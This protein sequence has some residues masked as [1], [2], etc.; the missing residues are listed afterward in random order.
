[1]TRRRWSAT[2]LLPALLCAASAGCVMPDQVAKL[3]KDVADLKQDL[4]RLERGQEAAAE[5]LAEVAEAVSSRPDE[6]SRAEFADV[7]LR[8]DAINQQHTIVVEQLDQANRRMDRLS[9][10]IQENRERIRQVSS[11]STLLPTPE[12]GIDP[13]SSTGEAAAPDVGAIPSAEA[14]YNAAYADF[15]KGNY[16]LA[17]SGFEEYA[18]R[19]SESDYADNALYWVGEC[20]FSQGNYEVAIRAFDRMLERYPDSDRAAAANLK[21]GLAYLELNEIRQ[22]VVQLRF[23]EDSYPI[24]DEA[25]IA[26]DKLASLGIER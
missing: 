10:G 18:T 11:T 14:L 4:E 2:I 16:A 17:I 1:M 5:R 24:S 15:S 26:R 23:V 12:S 7:R 6:I 13:L 8:L 3:R 19:F 22:A 9:Q 21:K 20:H 25:R